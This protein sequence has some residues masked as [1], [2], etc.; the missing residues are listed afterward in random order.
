MPDVGMRDQVVTDAV[1]VQLVPKLVA[2]SGIRIQ[3]LLRGCEGR[4]ERRLMAHHKDMFQ[5]RVAG[6]SREIL[7]DPKDR[8]G[9][10]RSEWIGVQQH[11]MRI[12]EV[13]RV[14]E[15]TLIAL[16]IVGATS[17][18]ALVARDE[19]VYRRQPYCFSAWI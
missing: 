11:E 5:V 10:N 2:K 9:R 15:L 3:R 6:R 12:M 14:R 17:G 4:S 18:G 1:I 19:R 8:N 7:M 16:Q 13:E